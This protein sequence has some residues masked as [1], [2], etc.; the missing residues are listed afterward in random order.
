MVISANLLAHAVG[1]EIYN[2][3]QSISG[4][5]R[6]T[7]ICVV[8]S[9]DP[10][11][12]SVVDNVPIQILS[13]A[14]AGNRFGY[15][16]MLSA[17]I[18]KVY[19]TCGG[20]P[21]WAIPQP[22]DGAA[23]QATGTITFANACTKAG[24]FYIRV[25]DELVAEVAVAIGDLHTDVSA[26]VDAAINDYRESLVTSGDVAGVLTLTAK[27]GGTWGNDISITVNSKTGESDKLPGGTTAVVVAMAGGA[28][29]P[30]LTDA[31]TALGVGD[32][33]NYIN[34]TDFLHGY[35]RSAANITEVATYVGLGNEALGLYEDIIGK[36]FRTWYGDV[37]SGSAGLTAVRAIGDAHKTDRTSHLICA[38]TSDSHNA[39]IAACAAGNAARIANVTPAVDYDGVI[40]QGIDPG[41]AT[42]RW[43]DETSNRDLAI[44]SGCATTIAE[45]GVLKL[46]EVVT[47]YHPADVVQSSNGY[48]RSA[49][50]PITWNILND[51]FLEFRSDYWRS[52]IIVA[53][54]AD[55]YNI[56]QIANVRDINDVHA[57]LF[58]LA[59][60]WGS[61]G[62]LF[63]K[64]YTKDYI[65]SG[66][67]VS[68]RPGGDGF[69]FNLRA[70]YR[71]L[72]S[73]IKGAVYFDIN[74]SVITS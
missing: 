30:D 5:V 36:P 43:T 18:R 40:M 56:T 21:I 58:A 49:D 68:L 74:I 66:N 50:L 34:C 71:A 51:L 16:F 29:D 14:D 57:S 63:D 23:V 28:T 31:I 12:T 70:I 10:A 52:K 22:E 45:D 37:Q 2:Q 60:Y 54:K 24:T 73:I 20:R 59:D 17:M 53:D 55:V 44:K 33:R 1:M 46:K 9:Y 32:N 69:D 27:S 65:A 39:I 48:R 11:I 35:D 7:A 4:S 26:L 61:L 72:T 25:A 6:E 67:A 13:D 62:Y 42:D 64:Q 15:G 19:E 47:M 8:G 41:A 38:P 3:R